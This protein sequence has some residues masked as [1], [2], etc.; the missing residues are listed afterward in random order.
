M[1]TADEYRAKAEELTR[2]AG[3]ASSDTM[4]LEWK[5]MARAWVKL[6]RLADWQDAQASTLN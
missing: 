6:A 5:A 4:A 3:A 2:M 1:M